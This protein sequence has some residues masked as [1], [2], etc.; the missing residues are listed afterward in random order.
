[1]KET[2]FA[3]LILFGSACALPVQGGGSSAA[4][5]K[6]EE[7]DKK[8]ESKARKKEELKRKIEIARIK[9][10]VSKVAVKSFEIETELEINKAKTEKDFAERELKQFSEVDMPRRLEES[11]LSVQESKDYVQDSKDE[12]AQLEDM[13]KDG[14]LADKTREIVLQRGRRRVE[15][16]NK[17][18]AL[19]E[20]EAQSLEKYKLPAEKEKLS[21][22]LKEK[23][24]A[25]QKA[26]R[27]SSKEK[28]E[29][30]I[31]TI[32]AEAELANLE[33]EL[34]DLEKEKAESKSH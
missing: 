21:L 10:E 16:A 11:K 3:L 8:E 24:D 22:T 4:A 31:S 29:K 25:L 26:E 33:M 12:L 23:V 19:Q 1:M 14:D 27:D 32:E 18:L 20:I 13:Y 9:I 2:F 5:P 15:R 28:L 34:A 6:E 7:K 17:R 30:K